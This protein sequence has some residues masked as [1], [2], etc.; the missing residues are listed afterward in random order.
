MVI[1]TGGTIQNIADNVTVTD[2]VSVYA[3]S[4]NPA[5][6]VS[7][8][9][10]GVFAITL[11]YDYEHTQKAIEQINETAGVCPDSKL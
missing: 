11:N 1:K 6:T 8:V 5:Q 7:D 4:E 10:D 3:L 2:T 9:K